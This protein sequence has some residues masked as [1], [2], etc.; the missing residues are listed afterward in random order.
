[1]N[2][3]NDPR[4]QKAIRILDRKIVQGTTLTMVKAVADAK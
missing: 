3:Q 2:R 1:M 4:R